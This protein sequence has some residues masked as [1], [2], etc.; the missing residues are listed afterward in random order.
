MRKT[1]LET[2]AL[3]NASSAI[4]GGIGLVFNFIQPPVSLLERTPFN[5]Y[6]I[7][8]LILAVIVGGSAL[9]SYIALV[10][11]NRYANPLA[12]L[13][14]LIMCGWILVEIA[15]IHSDHLLQY[16]YFTLGAVMMA[17]SYSDTK[18]TIIGRGMRYGHR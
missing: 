3:V 4:L 17:A 2:L 15:M 11:R 7:P 12:Y 8:G 14:G 10:E 9:L 1:L 6:V 13:A 5:S 18:R 16:L